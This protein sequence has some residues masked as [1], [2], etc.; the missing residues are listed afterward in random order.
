MNRLTTTKGYNMNTITVTFRLLDNDVIALFP[1]EV[2]SDGYIASYMHIGQ[3]SG[4]S[5][6]LLTELPRANKQQ[7]AA[8]LTELQTIYDHAVLVVE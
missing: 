4:A 5:K 7:Y 3:H 6:D 1:K 8:L 2:W